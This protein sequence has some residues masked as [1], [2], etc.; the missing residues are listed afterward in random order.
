MDAEVAKLIP[1]E[2]LYARTG[3]QKQPFNT[4][5]QL[6][7]LKK[8]HPEQLEQAARLLMVPDYFHYLL[9][10][11][12]KNEYTNATTSQLVNI[13]SRDWDWE[14]ARPDRRPRRLFEPVSAPGTP[15]GR[16]RPSFG[17]RWASTA[18]SSCPPP[19]TPPP[20]SCRS[21]ART[22]TRST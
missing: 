15:A 9:S 17:R 7:A 2:E 21:P 14:P 11:A 4:I 18:R 22:A 12:M 1:P 13:A 19:T 6:A 20:R 5:Y 16:L 8:E 10:G 3:I